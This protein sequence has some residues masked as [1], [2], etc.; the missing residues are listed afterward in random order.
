MSMGPLWGHT[1][2]MERIIMNKL[3]AFVAVAG[4]TGIASAQAISAFTG[5]SSFGSFFGGAI[6]G[7][8]VGY[9][10]VANDNIVVTN[11]GM[12]NNAAVDGVVDSSHEWGIWD[13]TGNLLGSG[14]IDPTDGFQ[15]GDFFYSTTSA[16]VA[17]NSGSQYVIAVVYSGTDG[18]QYLS[19]PSSVTTDSAITL[20]NGV[21][22]TAGDLGL[23]FP[24]VDSTNLARLGPNF[25]FIPAPASAALLGL[26]GLVAT[27]RRR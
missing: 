22:P 14:V 2:E 27:R 4:L 20:L 1:H 9:R 10:F 26:G 15:Q 17:L 19:S 3:A 13:A 11:V 8:A 25:N 24:G 12:L 7:D 21:A 23:T 6:A 5:G 18:D 16:N